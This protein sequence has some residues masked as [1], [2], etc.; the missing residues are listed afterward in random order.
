MKLSGAQLANFL[1]RPDGAVTVALVFGPDDGLVRER[2]DLIAKAVLGDAG[3]DPFR[4]ALLTADKIRQDPALLADEAAAMSLMGGRRVVRVRDA[5]DGVAVPLKHVLETGRGDALIVLEA[6]DLGKS[7]SLRK[8]CEAAD[9]AVAIPCYADG[10]REI[11]SLIRDTLQAQRI[12]IADEAVEYLV[13]NLGSDRGVSRQEIE[14]LVLYAGAGGRIELPDA[15]ASVGD[16]S[17][18]E[19]EDVV[20]DALDGRTGNLDGALTRLFLE[21]QAPVS[22]V[23]AVMRHAQRLH[24]CAAQ[25]AAGQPADVVVRGLRPPIFFKYTDRFRRQVEQWPLD[26]CERLL[27]RLTQAEL[28]LKRTGYPDETLCRHL[29]LHLAR[30]GPARR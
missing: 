28:D 26:R 27:K 12:Q 6:G 30:L 3:D 18:L 24:L 15:V 17:A 20:Y 22:I 16:S 29:L 8:L 2:A 5:A 10:P 7:S 25:V 1:K 14:K 23:R 11:A 9:T 21:G 19:L 13:G 4:L